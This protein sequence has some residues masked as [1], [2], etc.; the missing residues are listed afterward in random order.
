M[1]HVG[2]VKEVM[3]G[4]GRVALTP[5]ACERL[6]Q[7]GIVVNIEHD[8]GINSGYSDDMYHA[9][10]VQVMADAASLYAESELI[11]KVKQPL[12]SDLDH[13]GAQHIVFSYLH[14]AADPALVEHLCAIGITGIPFE[15]IRDSSGHLPLLA[16]MSQI[17]GRIS[18]IRGASLLFRNRGGRGVLIGGA[19]GTDCGK[20]VVLGVG[21]AGYHA[22]ETAV[23]LGAE[24]A[25]LD[26]NE[27]KLDRVRQQFPGV[28][29]YLSNETTVAELCIEADLVVGAVLL[30]GRRAPVVLKKPVIANMNAGSVIVDIA[31]DQGGCVEGIRATDADE[32]CY[33]SQGV[34]HS[35]VPNMPAAVARTASQSL[36][37]AISPYVEVLALQATGAGVSIN[38]D[39]ASGQA[40]AIVQQLEQAVAVHA[41]KVVDS[42]LLQEIAPG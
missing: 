8:A 18:V 30:A 12:Q 39:A 35:A 21:V 27:A 36:S 37:S 25:V 42:V 2:I 5:S 19:E 28:S 38:T 34:I 20:V 13:L 14:L 4:E 10:G 23:A 1:R 32:L 17:A 33:T 26:L 3:T 24:V 41:G 22:L 6:V 11:V 15:S 7:Q 31:I 16:P 9:A 40:A 29:T